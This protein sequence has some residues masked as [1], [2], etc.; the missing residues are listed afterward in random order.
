MKTRSRQCRQ[1]SHADCTGT[2]RP[3]FPD[4]CECECHIAEHDV[5]TL[6]EAIPEMGLRV[7]DRGT[8][9][10]L[11]SGGRPFEVEFFAGSRIATL[12]PDQV[13]AVKKEKPTK[14]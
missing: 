12:R 11:R 8:V 6:E 4:D 3:L 1:G 5:V 10:H 2:C 14:P 13:R 9:V 7:G